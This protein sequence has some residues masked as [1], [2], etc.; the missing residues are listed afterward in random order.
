M[1][2]L[3]NFY[4]LKIK[5]FNKIINKKLRIK[6]GIFFGSSNANDFIKN[7]IKKSNFIFE[8]GSGS[9]TLY[10]YKLKKDFIS[11]ELD[12][13]FIKSLSRK[14]KFL[15]KI[16]YINIGITGEFS[17][18]FIC[19]L[20]KVKEYVTSID[21]YIYK[22]KKID[23]ILIDGRFRVACCLNLLKHKKKIKKNDTKIILDDYLKR[24]HYSIIKKY[25]FIKKYGRIAILRP[26]NK[27]F[28]SEKNV[29]KYLHDPR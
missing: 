7:Q 23:L 26:R 21:K 18:P 22:L 14:K 3:N 13:D 10:Y 1:I 19:K 15:N 17:Y 27:Y 25:F 11:I 5:I 2:F 28:H 24:R 12:N 29:T 8:F 16:R 6:S 20:S 9:S 4:R